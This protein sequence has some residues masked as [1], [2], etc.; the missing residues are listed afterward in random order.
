[1]SERDATCDYL[2]KFILWILSKPRIKTDS[3]RIK[4]SLASFI[5]LFVIILIFSIAVL[6]FDSCNRIEYHEIHLDIV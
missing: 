4:E 2:Y 5:F 3:S 1:M 6:Y